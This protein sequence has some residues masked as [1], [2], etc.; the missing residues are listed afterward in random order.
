MDLFILHLRHYLNLNMR[1]G[2]TSFLLFKLLTIFLAVP[3]SQ[4]IIPHEVF[5]KASENPEFLNT[6]RPE[7]ISRFL[8][9]AFVLILLPAYIKRLK[10]INFP[11]IDMALI[12]L[13]APHVVDTLLSDGGYA[14]LAWPLAFLNFAGIVFTVYLFLKEGDAGKNKYGLPEDQYFRSLKERSDD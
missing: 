3:V 7:F 10:D 8:I 6:Y 13:F 2:R 14:V 9:T 1:M 4:Y 5:E 11:Y 12:F